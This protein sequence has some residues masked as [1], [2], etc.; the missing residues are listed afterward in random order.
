METLQAIET[1][2]RAEPVRPLFV[3]GGHLALDFANTIDDPHGPARFDHIGDLPGLLGWAQARGL[4]SRSAHTRLAS[5]ARSPSKES[6]R[7]VQRAHDLRD[8][9]QAVFGAVADGAD[10]PEA[11][12]GRLR[13][14]AADALGLAQLDLTDGLARLHWPDGGADVVSHAVAHAAY[15]LLTGDQLGRLKRCAG[16]PWLYLDQSKNSSRRW[17][18]MEDC[19]K[20][21]KMRRYVERRSARRAAAADQPPEEQPETAARGQDSS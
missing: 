5:A 12:W 1:G 3:V 9:V 11:A 18:T 13:Q 14:E 6:S 20:N 15:E 8:T 16:C 10:V 7:Q 19:G 4:L 17:C 21:A 2:V